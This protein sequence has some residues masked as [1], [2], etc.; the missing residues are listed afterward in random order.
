MNWREGP[1]RLWIVGTALW[2]AVSI[3]ME[4]AHVC[5]AYE[6]PREAQI[7]SPWMK[8]KW[9]PDLLSPRDTGR[10]VFDCLPSAENVRAMPDLRERAVIFI[11][12]PPTIALV[13]GWALLWAL[14]GFHR[15]N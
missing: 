11:L 3:Y 12:G 14:R 9:E 1:F 13:V 2:L 5:A 4:G 8:A 7:T 15:P 6:P 10:I